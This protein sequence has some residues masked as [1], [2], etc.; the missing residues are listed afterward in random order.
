MPS[1]LTSVPA[2]GQQ[3][4][5][6]GPAG[7]PAPSASA[8]TPISALV[9][10]DGVTPISATNTLP[11]G[12]GA[13][14]KGSK[15]A[16]QA[17]AVTT[18]ATEVLAA[19]ANRKSAILTNNGAADVWLGPT[20]GIAVG[21]GMVLHPGDSLTDGDSTDAWYGIAVSGS[22]SVAVLEIA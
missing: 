1:V 13:L 9:G 22:V 8:I 3:Q 4:L 6:Y 19:N 20:S 16:L 2:A 11:V 18:S 5:I 14:P 12:V 10:E 17:V 7:S 15:S 21:N